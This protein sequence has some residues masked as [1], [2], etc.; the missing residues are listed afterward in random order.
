M[1]QDILGVVPDPK[2]RDKKYNE[3]EPVASQVEKGEIPTGFER[4]TIRYI[5]NQRWDAVYTNPELRITER[6]DQSDIFYR[7]R[8][9][10]DGKGYDITKLS[11]KDKRAD[12]YGY[13]K[14]YCDLCNIKRHQIGIFTADRAVMVYQGKEYSVNY[15]NYKQLAM[16]GVDIVCIEKEGIVEK[17]KQFTKGVGIALVQSQGFVSEYGVMLAKEGARY[18]ANVMVVTDFDTDGIMIALNVEGTKRIGIDFS[19]IDEI[20]A[21]ILSEDKFLVDQDS[22]I[23]EP[24]NDNLEPADIDLLD[25]DKVAEEREVGDNWISLQNL[26]KGLKRKNGVD[27]RMVP[28]K[29]TQ[30]QLDCIKYLRQVHTDENGDEIGYMEFLRTRRIELN[31]IMTEIGPKRFWNWLYSK[32]VATFPKRNYLRVI[33]V[34][35]YKLTL[36]ILDKLGEKVDKM[37]SECISDEVNSICDELRDTDGLLNVDIKQDEIHERLCELIDEDE[38]IRALNDKLK[39]AFGSTVEKDN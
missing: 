8:T 17:L 5:I 15:E 36:P 14:I 2:L 25:I 22:P 31:S 21:Q 35:P 4:K 33:P 6:W 24:D 29:R 30:Q 12:L 32:I 34:P 7:M 19:S 37:V 13:I 16:M 38:S 11:K 28:I 20:N 23:Y 27:G 10:L 39:D 1:T 3:K 18:Q 9:L 26:I